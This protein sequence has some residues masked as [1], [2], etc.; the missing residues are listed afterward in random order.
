MIFLKK[1]RYF[2]LLLCYF[3]VTSCQK[4]DE[5][6]NPYTEIAQL[7]L[8]NYSESLWDMQYNGEPVYLTNGQFN[9]L[10]GLGKITLVNKETK[11]I[12]FE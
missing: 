11:K 9:I 4:G 6:I 12:D 5:S 7:L 3:I 2:G 1:F 10:P 8:L